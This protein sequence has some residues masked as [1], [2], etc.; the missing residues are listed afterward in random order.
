MNMIRKPPTLADSVRIIGD[1]VEIL[2]RRVYPFERRWVRCAT[3]EDVAVAIEQMVTQSSGPLFATTAGMI[4]A[5]GRR[6]TNLRAWPPSAC[7][8]RATV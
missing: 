7:G 8:R 5:S 4:L 2:D 1:V 6:A 3:S